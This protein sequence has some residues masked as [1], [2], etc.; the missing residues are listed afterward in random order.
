MTQALLA[1]G[2]RPNKP[3]ALADGLVR[4]SDGEHQHDLP[5]AQRMVNPGLVCVAHPRHATRW[6]GAHVMLID[7]V[8]TTGASL[9]AAAR[10]LKQAGVAQAS[11]WVLARTPPLRGLGPL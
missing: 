9:Q 5:R 3:T 8:C 7:D 6:L 11:A 2:P 10:A 1:Q 4:L